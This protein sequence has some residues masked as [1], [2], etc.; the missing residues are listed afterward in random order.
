MEVFLLRVQRTGALV[1]NV[2][3]LWNV[4]F[5]IKAYPIALIFVACNGAIGL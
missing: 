5:H 2:E 3:G 4:T 1:G